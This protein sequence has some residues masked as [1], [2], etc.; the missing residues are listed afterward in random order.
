MNQR[1]RSRSGRPS[2]GGRPGRRGAGSDQGPR[3]PRRVRSGAT[4]APTGRVEPAA[5]G[6]AGAAAAADV[7]APSRARSKRA[8]PG[9]RTSPERP[10]RTF[11]GLSTGR[12]VI[13]GVVICAL[14]LTLAMPLRTYLT[15]RS[16]AD[17]LASEQRDLEQQLDDLQRQK[18]QIED[19][20]WV[21][22]QGRER[23]GLVR[24]GETPYKVQLPGDYKPPEKDAPP[25][26]PST[27][28]WHS[29]LWQRLTEP[30]PS[31][32]PEPESPPAAP[33]VPAPAP[34]EPGVP[35]G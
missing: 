29:D 10:E 34:E 28:A 21:A 2:P 3:R 15:Q 8:G 9:R 24:P 25:P 33:V 18:E 19:P 30:P 17:R 22:T 35:T 13:L 1:G 4:A 32:E 26:P 23:L 6:E 16:E 31:V 20:A 11:F 14:A 7:P 27:G 12:A 5:P